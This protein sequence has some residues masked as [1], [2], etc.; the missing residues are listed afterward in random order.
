MGQMVTPP[1]GARFVVVN[2]PGGS[3]MS[4]SKFVM[5]TFKS[6]ED[7]YDVYFVDRLSRKA[8][9]DMIPLTIVNGG[10]DAW[11]LVTYDV[12]TE[13]GV[14]MPVN[15]TRLRGALMYSLCAPVGRSAFLC[16]DPS[17]ADIIRD[18][19]TH[20]S[21]VPVEPATPEAAERVRE[22]FQDLVNFMAGQVERTTKYVATARNRG[23]AARKADAV[24][25][26]VEAALSGPA[27]ERVER[28]FGAGFLDPIRKAL[29]ELK[30]VRRGEYYGQA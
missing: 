1:P 2:P 7:L 23:G 28:A 13:G 10:P 25:A 21:V 29:T 18:K 30:E 27:A 14:R 4:T 22:A 16:P 17:A 9:N 24:I 12:K 3:D 8:R 11:Y 26:K 15:Y 20:Y 6:R 5:R 19:V